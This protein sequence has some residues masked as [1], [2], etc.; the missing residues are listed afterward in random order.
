MVTTLARR[1]WVFLLRGLAGILFGI[2]ALLV[3]AA[4]L[5]ALVVLFGAYALVNGIFA[6]SHAFDRGEQRWGWLAFEGVASVI[7]G[8]LILLVPGLSA[9]ALVFFIAAWSVITGV[10]QVVTAVRLRKQI[11]HEWLLGLSGALSMAFGILVAAF[12]RAGA[13]AIVVWIAAYAI[14]FGALMVALS[15][16]LRAYGRHGERHVPTTGVPQAA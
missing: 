3:P 5:F 13:L 15:L 1:W 8:L 2:S 9:I 4:G 7:A 6:F 10:A 11:R 14:V 16:R 12:P